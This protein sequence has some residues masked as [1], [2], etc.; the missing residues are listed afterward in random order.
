MAVTNYQLI[1]II[2]S[3]SQ[4]KSIPVST[5]TYVTFEPTHW[6]SVHG[7]FI[8][9]LGI[10]SGAGTPVVSIE[11]C[12]DASDA[13]ATWEE[14]TPPV[15]FKGNSGVSLAVKAI[16]TSTETLYPFMRLKIV[17]DA[18]STAIITSV[19]RTIRGTN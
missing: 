1:N 18:T 14:V 9:L 10:T 3:K 19:K 6:D 12:I 11:Q 13:S 8:S 5:T 15:N 2:E 16:P 7:I 17:T 4:W